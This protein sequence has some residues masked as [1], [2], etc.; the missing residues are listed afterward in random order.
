M[1]PEPK[2]LIRPRRPL[3][4]F[5]LTHIC[6][7]CGFFL[8]LVFTVCAWTYSEAGL[9]DEAED[10]SDGGDEDDQ[11]VVEGQ[12]GGGNQH[13]ASPAEVSTAEQQC[14]D[15]GADLGQK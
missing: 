11:H 3:C 6:P 13:V 5:L 4:P 14:G 8:F 12:D 7:C 15:G 10:V 9:T 2:V 1:T